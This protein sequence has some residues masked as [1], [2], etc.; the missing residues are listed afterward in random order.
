MSSCKSRTISNISSEITLV[1][2]LI[3]RSFLAIFFSCSPSRLPDD[4]NK[5]DNTIAS[6]E[7]MRVSKPNGKGSTL[8]PI[9]HDH[10]ITCAIINQGFAAVSAV[11]SESSSALFLNL[12]INC[13]IFDH[14]LIL[15]I[16]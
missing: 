1:S 9:Q 13:L 12:F 5:P 8:N 15:F 6:S 2:V 10:Q 7:T 16:R 3:R 14:P 11:K 4:N